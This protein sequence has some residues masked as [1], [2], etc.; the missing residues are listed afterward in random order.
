MSAPRW[1]WLAINLAAP[2]F[3][4]PSEPPDTL[5]LFYRGK[6]HALSGPSE[7]AKTLLAQIGLLEHMRGGRGRGAFADFENDEA[8]TRLMLV[9]LGASLD[10]IGS[11]YYFNPTEP[12]DDARRL[13]GRRR[14][15][16]PR[17]RL[18]SRRLRRLRLGRQQALRRRALRA[19]LDPALLR[20]RHR[21]RRRRPRHEEPRQSRT[22]PDRQRTQARHRRRPPRPRVRQ[23]PPPR[24]QR[25]RPHRYAQ[26]QARPPRRPVAAEV[27]LTS[28]PET[29]AISWRL[30]E[31]DRAS[32]D[33][34]AWQPTVL[35]AKVSAWLAE[36]AAPVPRSA[37]EKAG[38]GKSA[39]YVRRA[40]DALLAEGYATET[41]GPRGARLCTQSDPSPR[42]ARPTSSRPRPTRCAT[43]RRP[44][45][46]PYRGRGRRR[47]QGR[48]TSAPPA[49]RGRSPRR[50]A[51][52]PRRRDRSRPLATP[53]R[54]ARRG[55]ARR[56]C[57][58]R[59]RVLRGR[60]GDVIEAKTTP[61]SPRL[62]LRPEEAAEAIGS[63]GRS[64]TTTSEMSCAGSAAA[65]CASS[66]SP[67][68]NAGS[69]A[70]AR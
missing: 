35:M 48:R 59:S 68:S 2:E 56:P 53:R 3:A 19:H 49:R 6:R 52:S 36:Q 32:L 39:I 51:T 24:R 50:A 61:T 65:G 29:H 5:G 12:P 45:P 21:D 17:H 43:P 64:S 9:E 8:T 22:L 23:K 69:I 44:R 31:A 63:R 20:A 58:R 33:G 40:L 1:S 60:G 14:R 67:S 47:R 37:V 66:P 18:R 7:A 4:R 62:A 54:K 30:L 34:A 26:R 10:E 11:V 42:P 38:L 55:G 16:A 70:T 41:P 13:A 28:D 27:E 57:L 15:Y 46:S 25:P